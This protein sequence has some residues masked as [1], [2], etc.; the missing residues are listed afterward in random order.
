MACSELVYLYV[1]YSSH[2]FTYSHAPK[3]LG[4]PEHA[5][6]LSYFINCNMFTKL[7]NSQGS[8]Q[9]NCFYPKVTQVLKAR[10]NKQRLRKKKNKQN[11]CQ[12]VSL[13]GLELSSN[14]WTSLLPYEFTSV[15]LNRYFLFFLHC[16][17][18]SL[19]AFES[20]WSSSFSSFWKKAIITK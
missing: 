9:T 4:Q 20:N 18:F 12:P 13:R 3:P 2:K 5:Y 14:A 6:Y 1:T 16:S 7:N 17:K 10:T 19:L 11:A 8:S 15:N